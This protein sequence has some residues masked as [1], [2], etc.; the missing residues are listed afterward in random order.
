MLCYVY[1][2]NLNQRFHL[3]YMYLN[4]IDNSKLMN[5]Y[6]YGIKRLLCIL[7]NIPFQDICM[8]EDLT[9]FVSLINVT[10]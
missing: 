7:G 10:N 9:I 5:R 2:H 1:D 3:W 4:E 8:N 6:N